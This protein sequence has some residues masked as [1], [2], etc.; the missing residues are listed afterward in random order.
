[1]AWRRTENEG[2]SKNYSDERI[3][4]NSSD[5]ENSAEILRKLAGT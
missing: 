3:I 4:E 2:K 5:T 1:M